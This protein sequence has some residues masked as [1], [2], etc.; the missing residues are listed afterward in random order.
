[1]AA[2][3]CSELADGASLRTICKA[4]GMPNKSTVFRWLAARE[5]FRDQYARARD[6]QADALAE[7]TLD[8]ADEASNDWMARNDPENPGWVV[9]GEHIQ[10]SRLRVDAR[11]WFASK[12]APKK[13]GEKLELA[14][15]PSA[16]LV[17]VLNVTI[18]TRGDKS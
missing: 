1:M 8:I 6:A 15:D 9:N 11:K 2:R 3:I 13:Y 4:D 10:R 12:V 17:P 14:G 5:D 7:E 16:P 18:G